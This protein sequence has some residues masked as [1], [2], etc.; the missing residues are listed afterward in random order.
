MNTLKKFFKGFTYAFSGIKYFF[1]HER[2]GK[3]QLVIALLTIVA[4]FL[5]KLTSTEWI[6]ALFCIA[7]VLGLEMVNSALE[8]LCNV[9]QEDFH[10][11]IKIIKDIAAG[12]VLW[13]SLISAIIGAIIFLPKILNLV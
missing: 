7:L 12:A 6:M 8:N 1:L 4:G 5:L 10:L 11:K 9:V 3:V 13:A 2:N